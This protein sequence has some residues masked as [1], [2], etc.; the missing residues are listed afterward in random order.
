MRL[1]PFLMR[2]LFDQSA[3]SFSDAHNYRSLQAAGAALTTLLLMMLVFHHTPSLNNQ[4]T[5]REI[6][7]WFLVFGLIASYVKGYL[8]LLALPAS[9]QMRRL[10]VNFAGAFLLISVLTNAFQS[11]DVRCY[12]N[13]GWTQTHYHLNPYTVTVSQ[14]PGWREDP[15]FYPEWVYNPAAYGFLFSWL[16]SGIC[17]AAKGNYWVSILLFKLMNAGAAALTALVLWRGCKRL[18]LTNPEHALYLFLWSPL[19]LIHGVANA[20]NDILMAF[21]TIAGLYLA[22]RGNWLFVLPTLMLGV[23]IKYGSAVIL[24]FAFLFL[25]RRN[26]WGRAVASLTAA[27]GVMA[28]FSLP[29]LSPHLD[30]GRFVGNMVSMHRSIPSLIFFPFEVSAT[31]WPSFKPSAEVI[32]NVIRASFWIGFTAFGLWIGLKRFLKRDYS[33][34]TFLRDCLLIQFVLICIVSSKYYTWYLC[35]IFPLCL[36]LPSD[37]RLRTTVLA[38]SV[39]HLASLTFIDG[40][41]ALNVLVTILAPIAWSMNWWPFTGKAAPAGTPNIAG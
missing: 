26:G 38:L 10:I 11:I 39:A 36:W 7:H 4:R 37:D 24:P 31:W 23:L 41:H 33:L 20:H 9:P 16:A 3:R 27:M 6:F 12:V 29:Y 17:M 25:G 34:Q 40:T 13:L 28:A 32:G 22:I 30:L 1:H 15:M 2:R 14:I 19:L 21:F 5:I 35:M 8:A 18:N